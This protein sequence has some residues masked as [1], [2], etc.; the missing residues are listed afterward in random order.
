MFDEKQRKNIRN[1]LFKYVDSPAERSKVVW[2]ARTL[3][4]EEVKPEDQEAVFWSTVWFCSQDENR[5]EFERMHRQLIA[6]GVS[7][8]D[9]I[10]E[11]EFEKSEGDITDEG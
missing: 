3:A 8:Y 10:G 4:N 11:I 9:S 5:A 7:G 2:V 1:A 6:D